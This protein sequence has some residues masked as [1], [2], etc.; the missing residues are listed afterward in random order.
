LVRS[1]KA[2]GK[3]AQ[4]WL[5]DLRHLPAGGTLRD[6]YDFGERLVELGQFVDIASR[7]E[8]S[9][10]LLKYPSYI[11]DPGMD[12]DESLRYCN[13]W[14]DRVVTAC[15]KPT[16]AERR[17]ATLQ[18]ANEAKKLA[19]QASMDRPPSPDLTPKQLARLFVDG[20]AVSDLQGAI[21]PLDIETRLVAN[22]SL[23]KLA[24]ALKCYRHENGSYPKSLNE[25]AP[26]YLPALPKDPFGGGDWVYTPK[27][28]SYL[29]HP[30]SVY[31]NDDTFHY[32]D[33]SDEW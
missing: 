1:R 8:K 18:I 10:A 12:W 11:L 29:I 15:G 7:R 13:E 21:G 23:V 25:L 5:S 9:H 2:T 19:E 22:A 26:K 27:E 17:E 3:R 20:L 6:S 31:S 32:W 16:Y 30:N 4:Q 33:E 24:M 28:S 14:F